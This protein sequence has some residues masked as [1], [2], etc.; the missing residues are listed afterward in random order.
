MAKV[1]AGAG[2]KFGLRHFRRILPARSG[3]G[4][5]VLYQN[6][7]RVL[8]VQAYATFGFSSSNAAM[9]HVCSVNLNTFTS[10]KDFQF[11]V[12]LM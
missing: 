4:A 1:D 7:K 3:E 12:K 9:R 5:L 6:L 8:A 10:A 11:S 2:G